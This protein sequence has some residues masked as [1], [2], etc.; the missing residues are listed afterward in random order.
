MTRMLY[1]G[2]M[3]DKPNLPEEIMFGPSYSLR[4]NVK[5]NTRAFVA[6]ILAWAGD[7]LLSLPR[8]WGVA[9][10]AI[11]ALVPLLVG[12]FWVRSFARWVRGMDEMH[13][14]LSVEACLFAT[15][16]TLFVIATWHILDKAGVFQ[17][18]SHLARLH[19]DSHFHTASF[20]ISLVL[21]FYFLG[22]VQISR[23]YK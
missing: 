17:A 21:G 5:A 12:L 20:P 6:M 11:I 2:G 1:T 16:V 22:Y 8:E 23:R 7:R 9:Q 14:W 19:L 15:G 10:R 3:N 4:A 13:R 18:G